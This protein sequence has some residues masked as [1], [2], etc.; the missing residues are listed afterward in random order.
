MRCF[1]K[2]WRTEFSFTK[3]QMWLSQVTRRAS[4]SPSL[5]LMYHFRKSFAYFLTLE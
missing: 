2:G 5:S 4:Q 1:V 3:F